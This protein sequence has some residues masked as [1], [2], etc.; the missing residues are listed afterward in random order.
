MK[1]NITIRSNHLD[2]SQ[3]I[4]TI[5]TKKFSEYGY[6]VSEEFTDKTSLVISIGGDGSF[7]RAA[8]EL[9]FPDVPFFC[10]NT[11]HLGFFAEILPDEKEIDYFAEKLLEARSIMGK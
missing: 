11:G 7:L 1:K 9:D 6:N 2:I 5:I 10:I 4:K 3:K 8:R